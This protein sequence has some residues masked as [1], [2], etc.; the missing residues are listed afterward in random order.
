MVLAI[1]WYAQCTLTGP[2]DVFARPKT[3][4]VVRTASNLHL[5]FFSETFFFLRNGPAPYH[6]HAGVPFHSGSMHACA[7]PVCTASVFHEHHYYLYM[8]CEV[9]HIGAVLGVPSMHVG[10]NHASGPCWVPHLDHRGWDMLRSWG[11][12]DRIRDTFTC[13]ASYAILSIHE[14]R[15]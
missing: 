5:F 7:P 14:R 11:P 10:T 1:R 2:V 3:G 4:G 13:T 9:C 15:Y 8:R 12:I 6:A